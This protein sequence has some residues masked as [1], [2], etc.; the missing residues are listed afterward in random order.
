MEISKEF[1]EKLGWSLYPNYYDLPKD[2]YHKEPYPFILWWDER[3]KA[4]FV[5]YK[6]ELTNSITINGRDP[7][8]TVEEYDKFLIPVL[9]A[10]K[11][12]ETNPTKEPE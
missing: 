10:L 8:Q 9:K 5:V 2:F 4:F 11:D 12:G 1:I 3:Y 6:D 7:I